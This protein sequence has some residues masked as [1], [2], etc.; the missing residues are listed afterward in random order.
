MISYT[1]TNVRLL[2]LLVTILIFTI[3]HLSIQFPKIFLSNQVYSKSIPVNVENAKIVPKNRE[4]Y[5]TMQEVKKQNRQEKTLEEENTYLVFNEKRVQEP[6]KEKQKES[7]VQIKP[8]TQRQ[9]IQENKNN[10]WR[11]QIPKINLDVHIQEGTSA[12]VLLQAVGHFEETSKW[13]G[14]V[15][16]AGHNRG[17]QCNFF[18]RIKELKIGDKIIYL[19]KNGKKEYQVQTN[20]IILETDWSYLQKTKDNRITLIT[21]EENRKEYRRCIQAVEIRNSKLE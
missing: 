7:K 14:N 6:Q 4:I 13:K 17:Y 3:F 15:G 9:V 19:T 16:L 10:S 20:K 5:Q 2:T 18:E 11:L 12:T 1:K 21:C 8:K